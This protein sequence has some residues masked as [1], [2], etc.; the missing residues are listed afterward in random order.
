MS[1]IAKHNKAAMNKESFLLSF[2]VPIKML[3]GGLNDIMKMNTF[4]RNII[5]KLYDALAERL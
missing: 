2:S 1:D 5:S 3:L 4:L